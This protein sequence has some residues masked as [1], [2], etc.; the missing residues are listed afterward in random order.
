M[1]TETKHNVEHFANGK[2][3]RLVVEVIVDGRTVGFSTAVSGPKEDVQAFADGEI[4][5]DE[6][7]HRQK[8]RIRP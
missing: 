7:E 6:F 2:D 4:S 3:A 1:R 5:W 8:R